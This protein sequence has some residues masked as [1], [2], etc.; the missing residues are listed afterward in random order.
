MKKHLV[1]LVLSG[2]V[3]LAVPALAREPGNPPDVSRGSAPGLAWDVEARV[4]AASIFGRGSDIFEIGPA[5]TLLGGPRM[6][7]H[8]GLHAMAFLADLPLRADES[9]D[10]RGQL[11]ALALAPTFYP[12]GGVGRFEPSIALVGGYSYLSGEVEGS[13]SEVVYESRS[14]AAGAS[15]GSLWTLVAPFGIGA[16]ATVLQLFV[17][18]ACVRVSDATTS[19]NAQTRL[20]PR[21][22]SLQVAFSLRL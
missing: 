15:L 14:V 10:H 20:T 6:D 19:C 12:L 5:V 18:R 3:C 8:F 17:D 21:L 13:V 4:G 9:V 7:G 1:A 16:S 2:Q 22:V 11:A